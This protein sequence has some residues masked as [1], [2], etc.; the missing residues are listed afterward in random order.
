[1]RAVEESN[2]ESGE[3]EEQRRE[4]LTEGTNTEESVC[5][6]PS[7]SQ[8]PSEPT[9]SGEHQGQLTSNFMHASLKIAT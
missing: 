8:H 9:A 2:E 5:G 6:A 4:E 1:M 3:A 7:G